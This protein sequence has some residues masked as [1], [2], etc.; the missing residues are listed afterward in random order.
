MPTPQRDFSQRQPD[1]SNGMHS[2]SLLD[3]VSFSQDDIL[4]L[5]SKADELE[6]RQN[7]TGSF[8]DPSRKRVLALLFFEPSTRTRMSFQIAAERLGYSVVTLESAA[9][10]S[11]SKGES[12]SDTVLNVL[13]MRPDGLVVRYGK[14]D[15][16]ACLLPTLE[17]PIFSA[18]TGVL[19]HPTQ[20]LLD[21]YT[22]ERICGVRDTRVLLVGDIRHSRVARSNFDVL[23]KLGAAVGICG[24]QEWL[25]AEPRK[26]VRV[27][28]NLDEAAAWCDVYMGL[29]VQHERHA[30]AADVSAYNR[31][32]GLTASRLQIL[33]KDAIIMHPG[34]INHGVEF[35]H[36]VMND[37]RY[38]VLQQVTNGVLIRAALLARAF[39]D[40]GV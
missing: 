14:D 22:I 2:R 25:P 31:E 4:E 35:S 12:L 37:P 26:N 6:R 28:S 21:A 9:T 10:S 17:I 32:F 13:A 30:K 1:A 29:R 24:P 38:R 40:T 5:F 19:A 11:L 23:G 18:G 20:A 33:K 8:G 36:E 34:P 15:D 27:F 3:T 16:L 7:E 39:E